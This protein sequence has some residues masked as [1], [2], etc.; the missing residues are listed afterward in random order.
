VTLHDDLIRRRWARSN[1]ASLTFG[2]EVRGVSIVTERDWNRVAENINP[3]L[4][5]C[6]PFLDEFWVR[7]FSP[8]TTAWIHQHPDLDTVSDAF[9]RYVL[10]MRGHFDFTREPYCHQLKQRTP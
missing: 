4:G 3:A 10:I 6:D 9:D 5:V 8:M 1:L 2:I 7:H